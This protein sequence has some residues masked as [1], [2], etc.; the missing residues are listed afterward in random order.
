MKK[1]DGTKGKIKQNIKNIEEDEQPS[2]PFMNQEIKEIFRNQN[3][4]KT[5]K[6]QLLSIIVSYLIFNIF[7]FC[8]EI[9]YLLRFPSDLQC[10]N[11]QDYVSFLIKLKFLFN[12]L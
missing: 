2:S 1:R 11:D 9:S 10:L 3:F 6:K 12:F 4:Y 7:N 5:Q 8:W